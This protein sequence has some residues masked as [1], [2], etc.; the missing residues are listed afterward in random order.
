[1]NILRS[2]WTGCRAGKATIEFRIDRS[3]N[4]GERFDPVVRA[5]VKVGGFSSDKKGSFDV[6]VT[7][8]G[9]S[10]FLW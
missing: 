5:T 9:A 8:A 6:D 4:L 2:E 7:G 10:T 3:A 1:V